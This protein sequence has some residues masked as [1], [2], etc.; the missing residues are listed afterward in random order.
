MSQSYSHATSLNRNILR[1][2]LLVT[3]MSNY[4][5]WFYILFWLYFGQKCHKNIKNGSW[6]THWQ[7]SDR[8]SNVV[9]KIS[10]QWMFKKWH[11]KKQKYIKKIH[12]FLLFFVTGIH[13]WMA[14]ILW[15]IWVSILHFLLTSK[16]PQRFQI[17]KKIYTY[18]QITKRSL[19]VQSWYPNPSKTC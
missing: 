1:R 13:F 7:S 18:L 9:Q 2:T 8:Y 12:S 14:W 11:S 10:T 17:V 3:K 6:A 19:K 4:E 16:V 15:K 5:K